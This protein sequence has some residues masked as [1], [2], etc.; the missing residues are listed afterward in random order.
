MIT[1]SKIEKKG[2][3]GNQLFQIASTIG[4]AKKYGHDFGFVNWQFNKY[5]QTE[6]PLVIGDDF[7]SLEEQSFE[8]HNWDIKNENYDIEGWLQT[9]KYFDIPYTKE[10]FSFKKAFQNKVKEKYK[11]AFAK[12]T[13]L[14]SIRRGD[15]VDHP[16]YFQISIKFYL[17]AL[18]FHFKKWEKVYNLIVLSDDIEYCKFHFNFLPNTY[19]G[20]GLN[21]IEQLCLGSLCD[22]FIISNSTFSWWSAWLGEK[23][24]SK[25]I[26]PIKNFRG[27]KDKMS[28]DK[29]FFPDRWN[30]FDYE[31]FKIKLDAEIYLKKDHFRNSIVKKY[32]NTYYE[33][34]K[35]N[36]IEAEN[37][38][39][40][41]SKKPMIYIGNILVP[42]LLI[43]YLYINSKQKSVRVT[44]NAIVS[45]NGIL[46]YKKYET[47]NDFGVFSSTFNSVKPTQRNSVVLCIGLTNI[48]GINET[49][50]IDY[51]GN[52]EKFK[53]LRFFVIRAW[54]QI[55][56][57]SKKMIKKII[58]FN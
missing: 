48:L 31:T 8:Y 25:V 28:N 56:K 5:F 2:N 49:L 58:K 57:R 20:E 52:F 23:E 26:C 6:L 46:K 18:A 15:F 36:C 53:G 9:E 24:K 22:D 14:I 1:F 7:V 34:E 39:P 11:E 47:K 12:K 51:V 41:N 38:I 10:L 16:D 44:C 42:P 27:K 30:K 35:F 43:F 45:I 29:D 17:D 32:I 21:G 37:E 50:V 4:I 40:I 54:I 33:V 19:F 13:I 55:I 3:L